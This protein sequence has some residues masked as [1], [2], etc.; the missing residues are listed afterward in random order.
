M[1]T[2]KPIERLRRLRRTA[3]L[4]RLVAETTLSPSNLCWPLFVAE[5]LA[6]SA[7]IPSLPGQSRHG[8]D[9]LMTACEHAVAS[10]VAAVLLFGI[11]ASKDATGSAAHREDGVVQKAVRAL[12]DRGFPLVVM[13][14]VCLCQY[15]DHGHCGL[16]SGGIVDN[17]ATLPVLARVAG[18][19]AAAGADIVAPSDMMDGRVAAIRRALDET[20]H[21]DTAILSYAVKYSSAYYGPFR[22]AAGSSPSFGDRRTHQMDPANR[23]EALRAA[24]RDL[25]EGADI[26]MVKPALAYLDIVREI[27]DHVDV[28]VA[29]YAVSGEYAMIEAAAA[30]GWI[31]RDA[32]LL[33]TLLGMRRAGADIIV[34]Y[35]A[36]LAARL[37]REAQGA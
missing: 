17:D 8:M 2:D 31:A 33:E 16:L 26:V 30:A 5:G 22:D 24:R 23:R 34:A 28:P 19:H 27:R 29:A 37:L 32:V 1:A 18:S 7:P 6:G 25:A 35:H 14:D 21:A 12:K 15:T 36:V 10:G 3:A 20:G 4:R 9:S 13:T 11:P